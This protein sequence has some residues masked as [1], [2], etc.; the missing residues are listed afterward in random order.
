MNSGPNTYDAINLWDKWLKATGVD[1]GCGYRVPVE[2]WNAAWNGH[3]PDDEGTIRWIV[4]E[5]LDLETAKAA[6][7]LE[8]VLPLREQA[9]AALNAA[10][11]QRQ[12]KIDVD[13]DEVIKT[14][15]G[16]GRESEQKPDAANDRGE[17]PSRRR[18]R[19]ILSAVATVITFAIGALVGF[20]GAYNSRAPNHAAEIAFAPSPEIRRAVPVELE[21]RKAIP[22]QTV[23]NSAA[24][25]VGR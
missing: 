15:R 2:V 24:R 9:E 19:W 18:N 17:T 7:Y 8:L 14:I 1:N 20:V 23:S 4:E 5:Y 11:Q 10:K 12:I 25:R 22:V 16:L 21:I 3:W 6:G 13:I